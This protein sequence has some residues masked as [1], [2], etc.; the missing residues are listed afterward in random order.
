MFH[1]QRNGPRHAYMLQSLSAMGRLLTRSR[2]EPADTIRFADRPSD[3][4]APWRDARN[5]ESQDSIKK[6]EENSTVTRIIA[7]KI[8]EEEVDSKDWSA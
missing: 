7:M 6:I 8:G 1:R 2:G 5:L 4:S 3:A